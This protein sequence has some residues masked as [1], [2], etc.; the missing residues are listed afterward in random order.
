MMQ[1]VV[2]AFARLERAPSDYL[3]L[4]LDPLAPCEPQDPLSIQSLTHAL[5]DCP[6]PRRVPG[7]YTAGRARRC[8]GH[9]SARSRRTFRA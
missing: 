4:L 9:F 3:Y 5:G 7:A 1:S 6:Y 2:Q 8:R